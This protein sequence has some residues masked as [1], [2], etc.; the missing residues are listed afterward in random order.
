MDEEESETD[1]RMLEQ[2]Q[3]ARWFWRLF[4]AFGV[5]Q[6]V[7]FLQFLLFFCGAACGD[8][9]SAAS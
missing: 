8:A 2:E 6:F 1:Q 5:V 4:L 9:I 7:Y 3:S